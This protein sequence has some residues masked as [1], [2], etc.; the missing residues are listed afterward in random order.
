MCRG[1]EI[2]DLVRA[3]EVSSVAQLYSQPHW[4]PHVTDSVLTGLEEFVDRK[5]NQLSTF[6]NDARLLG[7]ETSAPSKS[8]S[9][10]QC[11]RPRCVKTP[12]CETTRGGQWQTSPN[13]MILLRSSAS[14][15]TI[16]E[17]A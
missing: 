9:Y 11:K 7:L 4:P 10:V 8:T 12:V 6:G 1:F 14:D 13:P 2:D 15:Q 17:D 16:R 5:N 3:F